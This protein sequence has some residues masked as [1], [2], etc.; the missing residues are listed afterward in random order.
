MAG[1]GAARVGVEVGVAVVKMLLSGA[2]VSGTAGGVGVGVGGVGAGSATR[3][4]LMVMARPTAME[5]IQNSTCRRLIRLERVD[6]DW[7]GFFDF[8]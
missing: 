7:E 1:A 5:R 3:I 4:K 8:F 2:M 6:F